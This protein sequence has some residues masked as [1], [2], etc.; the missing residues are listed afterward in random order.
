MLL[1]HLKGEQWQALA[2]QLPRAPVAQA[3]PKIEIAWPPLLKI[4]GLRTDVCSSAKLKEMFQKWHPSQAFPIFR[5]SGFHGEA[6]LA[7]KTEGDDNHAAFERACS[8]EEEHTTRPEGRAAQLVLFEDL[9]KWKQNTP[10]WAEKM[11]RDTFVPR[12]KADEKAKQ[13]ERTQKVAQE[14]DLAKRTLVQEQQQLKATELERDECL[15]LNRALQAEKDEMHK[16]LEQT[17]IEAKRALEAEERRQLEAQQQ[18]IDAFGAQTFGIICEKDRE[19]QRLRGLEM[20]WR[21]TQNE[22]H[23]V[24]VLFAHREREMAKVIQEQRRMCEVEKMQIAAQAQTEAQAAAQREIERR[25]KDL[26]A[27]NEEK[28]RQLW[29][30]VEAK[31]KEAAAAKEKMEKE[32]AAAKEKMQTEPEI[33]GGLFT[34]TDVW[35]II[36][37]DHELKRAMGVLEQALLKNESVKKAFDDP[38]I[39]IQSRFQIHKPGELSRT[40]L[41]KFGFKIAINGEWPR[42][43]AEA[44]LQ[45]ELFYEMENWQLTL[46][47]SESRLIRDPQFEPDHAF[48]SKNGKYYRIREEDE[49]QKPCSAALPFET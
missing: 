42:N 39:N 20:H 30:L 23:S 46:Y 2:P 15:A 36:A 18:L 14:R 27:D 26:Q 44:L 6:I 16:N 3:Q 40:Q 11:L 49:E 34:E 10:G 5:H 28:N 38:E 37:E 4:T 17:R 33:C 45:E 25:F 12:L 19:A 41:R 22:L 32:A 43:D 21:N 7:F 31:E 1:T 24:K 8:L 13:T 29:K 48:V 9:N 35:R 47:N